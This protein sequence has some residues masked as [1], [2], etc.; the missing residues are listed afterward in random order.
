M[1]RTYQIHKKIMIRY[2]GRLIWSTRFCNVPFGLLWSFASF[3]FCIDFRFLALLSVVSFCLLVT[4]HLLITTYY[5]SVHASNKNV[6]IH[7]SSSAQLISNIFSLISF[8]LLR[9][10][11]HLPGMIQ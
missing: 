6:L 11:P 5:R 10:C 9:L 4:I 7:R 1:K 2:Y 3:F 8:H